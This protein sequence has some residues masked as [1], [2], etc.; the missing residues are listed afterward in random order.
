LILRDG[1]LVSILPSPETVSKRPMVSGSHR[2]VGIF[3]ARGPHIRRGLIGSELS[4]L[5]VAPAV[6][7]SL[8][9]PIPEE[10]QGKV[11]E[12]IYVEGH[13]KNNPVR[14]AAAGTSTHG[15]EAAPAPSELEDEEV[16]LERLRELGYIE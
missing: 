7:Y 11:P 4:I 5:D 10:L 15:Q 6:L 14:K 12:E 3:G 2:P 1:G 8:G 9:V 13:L 16:V